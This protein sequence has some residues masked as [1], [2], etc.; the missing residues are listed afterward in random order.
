M[1][2]I[3]RNFTIWVQRIAIVLIVISVAT[4][5][6]AGPLSN[7]ETT[8]TAIVSQGL[9]RQVT[10]YEL[11]LNDLPSDMTVTI[12]KK[13][14]NRPEIHVE[15]G[16][17]RYVAPEGNLAALPSNVRSHIEHMFGIGR[18]AN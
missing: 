8:G 7:Q 12:V 18:Q 2:E 13:G 16:R 11:K 4:L 14:A 10:A 1:R 9:L 6:V 3:M 15:H 17:Q 5:G